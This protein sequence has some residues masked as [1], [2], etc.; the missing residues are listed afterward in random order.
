VTEVISRERKEEVILGVAETGLSFLHPITRAIV[1]KAFKLEELVEIE[2]R[3]GVFVS[4]FSF[5]AGQF[6]Q[7]KTYTFETKQAKQVKEL[8]QSYLEDD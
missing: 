8:I 7:K 4:Q 3:E 2:A 6:L 5:S 1:K